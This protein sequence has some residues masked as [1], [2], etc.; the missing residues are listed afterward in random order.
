[1]DVIV[2]VVVSFIKI[3]IITTTITTTL[4]GCHWC[5]QAQ[6]GAK[7]VDYGDLLAVLPELHRTFLASLIHH[8][9]QVMRRG[10][11]GLVIVHYGIDDM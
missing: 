5:R 11:R 2:I 3:M 4:T 7:D 10:S 6:D 1:L 9:R 8:L